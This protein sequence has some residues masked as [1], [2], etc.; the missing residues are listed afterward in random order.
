MEKEGKVD[1]LSIIIL[2]IVIF[3]VYVV[4]VLANLNMGGGVEATF[5]ENN[6]NA[7]A[8]F[9]YSPSAGNASFNALTPQ[10]HCT[11]RANTTV[12]NV[13]NVSLYIGTAPGGWGDLIENQTVNV[14]I[15]AGEESV[16][17]INVTSAFNEG[18]HWW[19][20]R[21]TDNGSG[22]AGTGTANYNT[23]LN[24]TFTIDKTGPYLTTNV[25]NTS[26]AAVSTEDVVYFAVNF[27]D[28]Y[29]SIHTVRLFV[30][31]SGAAN[32]EVN[33]TADSSGS[34]VQAGN[35]TMVNLSYTIP[36]HLLDDVLNFTLWVN[37]SV[38]NVNMSPAVVLRVDRDA[39]GPG[40]NLTSPVSLFNQSSGT[41][42]FNFTAI[43]NNKTAGYEFTCGINISLTSS[44]GN[45]EF[46][47]ITNIQVTN[48]TS[49]VNSTSDKSV[50]LS[51]GTYM[52]NVSCTDKAGNLNTSLSQNFTIDQ[53]APVLVNFS[54]NGTG[55]VDFLGSDSSA[56]PP[57]EGASRSWAQGRSFTAIGNFTDNLTKLLEADLQ[58]YNTSLGDWQTI[59]TTKDD[60]SNNITSATS[61]EAV[62]NLT[63]TPPSGRNE[64]EGNNVSFRLLVNDTLGNMNKSSNIVNI[65]ININ[66]TYAP[67]ITINATADGVA[68]INGSNITSSIPLISWA[69]AENNKLTSINVSVDGA[70]KLG[71]GENTCKTF[72]YYTSSDV[73]ADN[74]EARRNSSFQVAD[75]SSCRLSNG[76]HFINITAT[77]IW[78]NIRGIGWTFSV[79]TIG[80]TI[81]ITPANS[82]NM[83]TLS[84]GIIV[85]NTDDYSSVPTTT[86]T[87]S[88]G[89]S[90]TYVS[91]TAFYPF[92]DSSGACTGAAVRT[93]TITATDQA[94]N[95]NT[96]SFLFG[97]DNTAPSVTAINPTDGAVIDQVVDG[98]S[99]LNYS[100]KDVFGK[101]SYIGYY[102]DDDASPTQLN[103]SE[104]GLGQV[105]TEFY[106]NLSSI[107][108]TGGDHTLIFT[109][110]DS[111]GNWYNDT[112]TFVVRAPIP[113]ADWVIG[114][115]A[116]LGTELSI[117]PV[118]RVK[119]DSEEYNDKTDSQL[120][121]ETY[122]ILLNVNSTGTPINITLSDLD[123]ST[124]NWEKINS[125]YIRTNDSN[126]Y[127]GI[128][129]NWTNTI[130]HMVY[131]NNSINE[132]VENTN[133][134]YGTVTFPINDS[135]VEEFWWVEDESDLIT[136][137]GN[138]YNIS[139]CG[140]TGGGDTTFSAT[141]TTPCWNYTSG[142]RTEIY[143]PHFS[144]VVAVNDTQ[145]PTVT[146]NNPAT[147]QRISGFIPNITVSSDAVSCKYD[148][149]ITDS[150]KTSATANVSSS[151]TAGIIG[152]NNI[153]TWS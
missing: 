138:R 95:T 70:Y 108:F 122:E 131:V 92:N 101:V 42:S 142:G 153:C 3:L 32:N 2:S 16:V 82:T 74:V 54:I 22:V 8:T 104:S 7:S 38:N 57:F 148:L 26:N 63:F 151:A 118:F 62:F 141:R 136:D 29:T 35:D 49:Q 30:N 132:F 126:A 50:G 114:L 45:L 94:G 73:D 18:V 119:N 31:A 77:D 5:P 79:D 86:W 4:L 12:G 48:G 143:V 88:C 112:V 135:L 120:T 39:T 61:A 28:Q 139:Q 78:G 41:V 52:W 125:T 149:N 75:T 80:P 11:A 47:N 99:T 109:A 58:F 69:V 14:S 21:S 44:A 20:C 91:G 133:S 53:I 128:Q 40:I 152:N 10:F 24:R 137:T 33:I 144:M 93:L 85:T 67:T 87:S 106:G 146:I 147:T 68:M 130:L 65:T 27:T 116:T 110:N 124:A 102:L 34:L 59:N 43:D 107:N 115:N 140:Q 13:T 66:D 64:F 17:I 76:T 15:D 37:D 6:T 145:P 113:L 90:G 71:T 98:I 36:G 103:Y 83:T 46:A 150:T 89:G 84:I 134:Y 60:T 55:A 121:N 56:N 19:F 129:N 111:V 23:T 25:T 117:G 72:G 51:N 105:N 127:P 81:D 1:L 97:V 9:G 123:G 100:A 96:S